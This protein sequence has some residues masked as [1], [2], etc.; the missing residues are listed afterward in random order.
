VLIFHEGRLRR[1]V[2]PAIVVVAG[3]ALLS[4]G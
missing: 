4:L 2:I 1:I 3:I